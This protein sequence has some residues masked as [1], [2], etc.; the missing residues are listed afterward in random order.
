MMDCTL[1][2]FFW[3]YVVLAVVAMVE[4]LMLWLVEL[5]SHSMLISV[6]GWNVVALP[7]TVSMLPLIV[8]D[9]RVDVVM[10]VD[11]LS[12]LNMWNL[13]VHSV[14]FIFIISIVMNWLM[15]NFEIGIVMSMWMLDL[16]V[17]FMMYGSMMHFFMVHSFVMNWD[18]VGSSG[19]MDWGVMGSVR[20]L[21]SVG[22]VPMWNVGICI[23][24]PFSLQIA[25]WVHFV[26]DL[27]LLP[28]VW[29]HIMMM[30]VVVIQFW[31]SLMMDVVVNIMMSLVVWVGHNWA[32]VMDISALVY[33]VS[34]II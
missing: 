15:L 1:M 17:G 25:L 6:R 23:N 8:M 34:I 33:K 11:H 30:V 16:M 3:L 2:P 27:V 21:V 13:V 28:M 19:M 10:G 24:S 14:V 7:F 20:V 31:V 4:D 18:M 12:M 9:R 26:M 5:V 22:P 32:S 29:L